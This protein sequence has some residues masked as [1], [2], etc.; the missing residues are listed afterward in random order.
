MEHDHSSVKDDMGIT[1]GNAVQSLKRSPAEDATVSSVRSSS[2]SDASMQSFRTTSLHNVTTQPAL[3]ANDAKTTLPP[4]PDAL[5]VS[6]S[7]DMSNGDALLP[8]LPLASNLSGAIF[9]PVTSA[10]GDRDT[11]L[12]EQA[13]LPAGNV[14]SQVK[15]VAPSKTAQDQHDDLTSSSARRDA[16]GDLEAEQQAQ[17]DAYR[18]AARIAAEEELSR[19]EQQYWTALH[20]L[21]NHRETYDIQYD[22]FFSAHPNDTVDY[23]RNT[24]GPMHFYEAILLSKRV[25]KAEKA[26]KA[27]RVEARKAEVEQPFSYDQEF[28]FLSAAGEGEPI[29]KQQAQFSMDTCNT[30][31]IREWPMARESKYQIE[32]LQFALSGA[33]VE[34]WESGSSCGNA[35]KR[36]KIDSENQKR[37]PQV[38]DGAS[39]DGSTGEG[40]AHDKE[41]RKT[42]EQPRSRRLMKIRSNWA[43]HS[44]LAHVCQF[45]VHSS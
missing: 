3:L 8:K 12:Q 20:E 2:S 13:G 9:G 43:S 18:E 30:K 36:K 4:H 39:D 27:A 34:V 40:P 38:P 26:M 19:R 14:E 25:S 45:F 44:D 31:R 15:D 5:M 28:N 23:C 11:G 17:V 41:A 10:I 16:P 1:E 21:Q 7:R 33:D 35:S 22:E 37:K 42:G 32:E 6:A 29:I 24:F